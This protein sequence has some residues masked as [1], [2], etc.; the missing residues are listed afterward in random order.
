MIDQS[1]FYDKKMA[2]FTLGC[3]L[4][5]AETSTIGRQLAE[6]GFRKVKAGE[7]ADICVINTCTVTD[8]AD[9]KSRQA[10][11]RLIRQHPS[12]FIVVTGCY[13][14]LKPEEVS[15]LEGVDL[16]LGA[17]E[18]FDI[19]HYVDS[20]EKRSTAEIQHI[21]SDQ[22]QSFFPSLSH[23]DRTRFF[24]KV[25]DGCDYQCSYCTIPKARGHSR[26][27]TIADTVALARKA[28]EEGAQEIVLTGVNIG[29]FGRSTSE[30]FFDLIRALDEV[31]GIVRYR[32]GSVEPNL[33]THEIIAFVAT[34]K[35][36]A[37]H[38]HIPLQSGSNH[39]LGLMRRRYQRELF[40]EKV[41]EIKRL[42]PNAFIGV[43]VIVG[44]NGETEADFEDA[45]EFIRRLPVSQLHVFTY[46][47]RLNTK[48]L[49]IADTLPQAVRKQ[50]SDRMH[51]LSDEKLNIFYKENIGSQAVVLWEAN[52]KGEMM[53][54]F[55]E[56][57]LHI[58]A[59]YDRSRI[60][61]LEQVILSDFT[62]SLTANG[63]I[64][65]QVTR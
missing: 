9:K 34:S 49:E 48:A 16:V 20:L 31:E 14:Q 50:R 33:L 27:G 13:A 22:L 17:N 19:L 8:L 4:N 2:F 54:G 3:R 53:T 37:P 35:R 28:A 42:L 6:A 61:T 24:L 30:S 59:P 63:W 40:E 58:A 39:V 62:E 38:F 1:Q 43:D 52:H 51:A 21:D 60:N 32:I 11:H 12:A 55:T 29:D 46:S 45:M 36:F 15:S 56:N 25:Q 64:G 7:K 65:F 18:K 5:F 23:D 26:N 47:E 57:Y 10:I 41:Q 44:M